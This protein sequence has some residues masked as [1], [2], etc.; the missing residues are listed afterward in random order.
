MR[1]KYHVT[2]R[3]ADSKWQGKLE[4]ADRASVIEDTK[5]EAVA[6]TCDIARNNQPSSVYIHK[7]D[8]TIE[9]ERTYGND[10]YPPR[11]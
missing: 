2:H 5:A 6:K 11:G 4:G 8:G 1:K 9:D 3:S 10:P 7:M